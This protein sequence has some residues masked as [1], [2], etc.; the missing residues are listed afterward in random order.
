LPLVFLTLALA[1]TFFPWTGTYVGGY[2]VYS[3]G[4]WRAVSGNPERNPGLEAV[5]PKDII[6]WTDKVKSDWLLMIPFFLCLLLAVALSWADRIIGDR[7]PAVLPPP[8]AKIWP[9]RYVI[10]AGLSVAALALLVIQSLSGFGL[11]RAVKQVVRENPALKAERAA[12]QADPWKNAVVDY[13]ENEELKKFNLGR[14][15]WMHLAVAFTALGALTAIGSI[16]LE[17]RGNKPA[18]KL[19]LH[20]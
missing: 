9:S 17:R 20:Y 2:A 11:E 1:M 12:A 18:P 3:Q 4:M 13:K 15:I 7:S 5:A 14:T 10:V 8:V 6:G 19:L 16:L